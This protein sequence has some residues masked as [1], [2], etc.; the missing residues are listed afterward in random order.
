MPRLGTYTE[1][2]AA[3]TAGFRSMSRVAGSCLQT[4]PA[5]QPRQ[6]LTPDAA[7]C[8]QVR[9]IRMAPDRAFETRLT[10]ARGRMR[11]AARATG[12]TSTGR[13]LMSRSR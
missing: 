8:A 6:A 13:G 4:P 3:Q 5:V 10:A 11:L 7:G 9:M 1:K 2:F 12:P